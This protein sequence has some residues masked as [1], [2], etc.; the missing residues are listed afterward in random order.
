MKGV[1]LAGGLGNRLNPL[2]KVTNKHLLPVA[3][4]PMIY[5]PI[6]TLVDAGIT[7]LLIVTGG[8][9]AGDF[10]RLLGNGKE[11]GLKH[12]NYTYQEGHGGIAAALALAEHFA[13]NHKIVVILGDNIIDCNII[14][15][16]DKFRKQERG[17]RILLNEVTDA[18]RF[19]VAEIRG[20]K[21]VNV[22]E[23][24][25][26]P[27]TNYAVTG[28]YMFDPDVF[29]II[30]G[31]KPSTRNELEIVDVINTYIKRGILEYDLLPGH[32]T[33]SGTFFSLMRANL[34]AMDSVD[35]NMLIQQL[36]DIGVLQI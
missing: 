30:K 23:K 36:R 11:F 15:F 31:L 3:N 22:V 29:D 33:D 19:G 32:W 18:K 10:L 16:V 2:T 12:L 20:D 28:I 8:E 21:V 34:I 7:D 35:R 24:P 6:R 25:E 4:K 9:S 26:H 17:A 13:D 27:K 5:Y 14:E 1:V